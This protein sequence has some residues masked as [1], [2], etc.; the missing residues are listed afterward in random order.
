MKTAKQTGQ[1]IPRLLRTK[2]A[3]AYLGMSDKAI[4]KLIVAGR[5]PYVHMRH[6]N[7]PFLLDRLDLD[8]FI[9]SQKVPAART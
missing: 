3:A 5:L 1:I 2:Q 6:G 9:E 8:R 7:S 4:R